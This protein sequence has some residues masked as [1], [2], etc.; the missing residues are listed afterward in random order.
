MVEEKK[1]KK[2]RGCLIVILAI[3]FVIGLFIYFFYS[4]MLS[5]KFTENTKK[6]IESA[7]T[8]FIEYTELIYPKDAVLKHISTKKWGPNFSSDLILSLPNINSFIK[9]AKKK[10]NFEI[11]KMNYPKIEKDKKYHILY[12]DLCG[13][14]NHDKDLQVKNPDNLRDFCGDRDILISQI[15]KETE[16][17]IIMVILPNEKLVWVNYTGW[18]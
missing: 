12:S 16:I 8:K 13:N 3:I 18:F 14:L 17:D 5:T 10:Y 15:N 7:P 11:L 9:V 2:S 6:L 4:S 1:K